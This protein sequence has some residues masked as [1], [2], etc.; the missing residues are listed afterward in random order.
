MAQRLTDKLV[1]SLE[2]PASGNRVTY[3]VEVKG[4]GARVTA[5]GARAFVVNYR[6]GG[7]E[8]R[9]TI[10]DCADWSTVAA[11]NEARRLK[12]EIDQGRDPMAQRHRE[13]AVPTV[14][15]LCDRYLAEHVDLHNK[16]RTRAECRRIVERMIKPRLGR[17]KVEA[18]DR[19][20]VMR[21]HRELKQTPR[22][23]NHVIAI[24]SKML[25]LAEV[26]RLRPDGTNPC[27]HVRRYPESQRER[28]LNADELARVGAVL[29]Q[30]ESEG[31]IR[32]EIAACIRFL[33]LVGCRLNEA[34]GLTWDAIDA[35]AGVWRLTDAKTGARIVPLGAPAL[36]LLTALPRSGERVFATPTGRPITDDAVADAWGGRKAGPK[37]RTA[38]LGIRDRAGVSDARLHDLRHGY[39]TFAGHGGYNAYVVRDL[40]GHRSLTMTGRYVSRHVDPLRQAADVVSGQ[41]AAAMEGQPAEVVEMPKSGRR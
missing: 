31:A 5:A 25:N 32:P 4:L 7:R 40:M 26:W 2:P 13:R 27:R 14:A 1:R 15:V 10:G 20:D 41:I 24:L 16:A 37:L 39:G 18:L 6:A 11:R 36:A 17:L 21:L 23:A 29:R 33:A 22:Q 35:K 19:E 12:R 30:M 9:Y 8:R 28:F 3:D 38:R 34:V